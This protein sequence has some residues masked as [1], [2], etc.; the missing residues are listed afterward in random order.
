MQQLTS[1]PAD[2]KTNTQ[3]PGPGPTGQSQHHQHQSKCTCAKHLDANILLIALE[4]ATGK[5]K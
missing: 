1:I 5:A 2:P 4:I 3:K